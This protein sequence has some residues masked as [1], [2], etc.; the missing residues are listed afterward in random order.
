MDALAGAE[1][2]VAPAETVVR[3][4]LASAGT[5]LAEGGPTTLPIF[6][7]DAIDDASLGSSA[8]RRRLLLPAGARIGRYEIIEPLGAGGMGEVYRAYDPEL[9]R[10]LAIKILR[11]ERRARRDEARFLREAQA[12]ARLSHPNV[13]PVHD[14]GISDQGLFLAMELVE[15]QTLRGWLRE[16][17]RGWREIVAIFIEAGRGLAEAHAA[18]IVHRDFKPENVLVDRRGRPRVTDFGL[19]RPEGGEGG[20]RA[21]LAAVSLGS[22]GLTRSGTIMGTPAY[23]APEQLS[24]RKVDGRADLFAFCVVLYEA[25]FQTSPYG[26]ATIG[27]RLAVIVDG[28]LQEAPRRGVPRWLVRALSRGLQAEPDARW[29]SMEAL[30]GALEGG[31]QRRRSAWVAALALP[32]LALVGL[33]ALR[34]DEGERCGRPGAR[35]RLGGG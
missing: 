2:M 16:Q 28:K 32:P 11:E 14:V 27:E 9:D 21:R 24:G 7:D 18:G 34:G 25:L 15:G 30:L 22:S 33:L 5:I 13:V 10:W 23:M 29:P 4:T 35:R 1:T 26:G 19:A 3:E 31:L 8:R 12:M 6:S 17:E 20:S